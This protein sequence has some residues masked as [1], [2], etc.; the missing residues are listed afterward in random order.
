MVQHLD[1]LQ[2]IGIVLAAAVLV[3]TGLYYPWS[4]AYWIARR[5]GRHAVL[6]GTRLAH[7]RLNGAVLEWAHLRRANL[8]GARL[9]AAD[10]RHANL[11]Y[12]D[13]RGAD[14]RRADLRGADMTG[15]KL[16]NARLAEAR[17]DCVTQ[18]PKGFDPQGCGAKQVTDQRAATRSA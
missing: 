4:K 17:Y 3:G 8:R 15:A 6:C 11:I 13:L 5:H 2:A 7:A 14:L 16:A 1:T 12:A 9:A 18:W 10:L